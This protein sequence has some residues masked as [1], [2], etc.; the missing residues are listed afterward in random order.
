MLACAAVLLIA[1]G[2]LK[3]D[4][5]SA[6]L[7][8]EPPPSIATR[9]E[10]KHLPNTIKLH[11]RVYSG[12]QPE[13]EAGFAELQKLGVKTVISVDGIKPQVDAAK[14]Y[15][16]RYIHLPHGYDGV[17]EERARQLAK[18]IRDLPGPVYIHCHHGKHRSP[19]A[20]T[21]GCVAA[22]LV[23]PVDAIGILKLAGTSAHYRGLYESAEDV[24]P[25]EDA[26]LD[27]MKADF[28]E[29]AALP[30]MAEAMVAIEH[31]HARMKEVAAAGWKTPDDHPD[32]VPANEALLLREHFTELL[33][34]EEVRSESA[35]FREY[36]RES[37]KAGL[38]LEA[39]LRTDGRPVDPGAA[40]PA[41]DHITAN[42]AAC[43][44]EFRDVPLD[45]KPAPPEN[46]S[47][48]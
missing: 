26:L 5:E 6:S 46:R 25:L 33:R 24:R 28:P 29:V 22:G 21:V 35:A 2:Q 14:K 17:P 45:E 36:L 34:S 48:R 38:Q 27:A 39:A 20:A 13:G 42:C 41:L 10:T 31:A 47:Q 43:H 12:G 16:M 9:I 18:A 11:R 44:S 4:A 23:E 32:I 1:A 7:A 3:S 8:E 30:P 37:E 19:A 15:G 40:K